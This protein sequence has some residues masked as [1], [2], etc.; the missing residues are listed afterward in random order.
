M[1]CLL[2]LLL[3]LRCAAAA[4][5]ASKIMP[6]VQSYRSNYVVYVAHRKTVA[7]PRCRRGVLTRSA[8]AR[9][10]AAGGGAGAL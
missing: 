6:N 2:P 1:L 9:M 5:A 4:T 10:A 8:P 7:G 3:L